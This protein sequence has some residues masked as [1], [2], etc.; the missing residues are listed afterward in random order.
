MLLRLQKPFEHRPK[1]DLGP[2]ERDAARQRATQAAQKLCLPTII[3]TNQ[4]GMRR[5]RAELESSGRNSPSGWAVA[6]PGSRSFRKRR[7]ARRGTFDARAALE[8]TTAAAACNHPRRAP[9]SERGAVRARDGRGRRGLLLPR[10][11]QQARSRASGQ[12]S[13]QLGHDRGWPPSFLGQDVWRILL[14]RHGTAVADSHRLSRF[15][16][17]CRASSVSCGSRR[18]RVHVRAQVPPLAKTQTPQPL[19]T[20]GSNRL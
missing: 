2:E 5:D 11:S 10:M 7:P 4:M 13:P 18:E 3:F 16:R 8:R 15:R 1:P 19:P 17:R 20:M 6:S 12:A 9:C 14:F